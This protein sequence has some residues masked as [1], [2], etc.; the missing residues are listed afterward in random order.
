MEAGA[1]D[2]VVTLRGGYDLDQLERAIRDLQPL[3]IVNEPVQIRLD[4]SGAVF[5]GATTVALIEA[6]LRR[7]EDLGFAAPG[8][9]IALPRN[10]LTRMY[11]HRMDL[12][13]GLE[14]VGELEEEFERRDP[15]GFRPC[16]QFRTDAEFFAVSKE[17]AEAMSERC[18]TDQEA[19]FAIQVCLNELTENVL[20]HAY[21]DL[22]GFAVCQGTP[23]RKRFEVAIVD[24]GVG[25]RR[26]LS[27]NPKYADIGDD[28]TAIE[29]AL[30]PRV[31][32]TPERNSGIGLSI[33]KLLLRDNGGDLIVRSG[34]GRVVGGAG[35]Q[36][37]NMQ[38]ELPGTVVVMRANTD[39]PLDI[40]K[41]Y[42]ELPSD[43]DDADD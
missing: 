14:T 28:V 6:A 40:G 8:G 37:E 12:F 10:P 16:Q 22:G 19:K 15:V 27:K 36:A 17:L 29:T 4:L 21:T 24:L 32:A 9:T 20:H 26:S 13:R 7:I 42:E 11:L 2:C 23:K 5:I 3:F 31:T 34:L 38:V 18:K 25:I 1:P 33:T 39:R 41:I 30:E 35:Q 43:E